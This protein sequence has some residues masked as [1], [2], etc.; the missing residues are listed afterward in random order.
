MLFVG[1][2]GGSG[3]GEEGGCEPW[4]GQVEPIVTN[5][6]AMNVTKQGVNVY[7]YDIVIEQLFTKQDGT[8]GRIMLTKEGLRGRVSIVGGSRRLILIDIHSS[9]QHDCLQ[10]PR[11]VWSD[12]QHLH[13]QH[14]SSDELPCGVLRPAGMIN[15]VVWWHGCTVISS[16]FQSIVYSLDRLQMDVRGDGKEEA[17]FDVPMTE[18]LQGLIQGAAG[19]RV[20]IS[21]VQGASFVTDLNDLSGITGD[22]SRVSRTLLQFFDIAT[23]QHVMF[24]RW[25]VL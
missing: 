3:D 25:V 16:P 6:F 24:N 21:P 5:M 23:S 11:E 17:A 2:D 13:R 14:S 1:R 7:R 22:L 12:L 19:I 8:T 4:A 10:S 9:F 20:T 18:Q 15:V